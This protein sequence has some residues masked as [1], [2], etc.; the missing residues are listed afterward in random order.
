MIA[1]DVDVQQSYD[2]IRIEREAS[3]DSFFR[4]L[5]AACLSEE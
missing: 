2:E 3:V 5:L 4:R 1:I